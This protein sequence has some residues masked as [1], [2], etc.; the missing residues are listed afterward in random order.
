MSL[1]LLV[2]ATLCSW[3][4]GSSLVVLWGVVANTSRI[5]GSVCKG[6]IAPVNL[7]PNSKLGGQW[8]F[9]IFFYFHPYLGKI[10]ILT[11]IF[12]MGWN[13]QLVNCCKLRINLLTR[14]P[15]LARGVWSAKSIRSCGVTLTT[16]EK[17]CS[18]SNLYCIIWY[19]RQD[20]C[21]SWMNMLNAHVLCVC[22]FQEISKSSMWMSNQ[23]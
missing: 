3:T 18:C 22:L 17:L 5:G 13:H 15:S 8:W 2:L 10:P 1:Q 16:H 19:N 6:D 11:N 7:S 4:Q 20:V 9:Q 12:Q 21:S 23:Q 14:R